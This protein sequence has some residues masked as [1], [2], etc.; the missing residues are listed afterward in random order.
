[1]KFFGNCIKEGKGYKLKLFV[2]ILFLV[3]LKK[4]SI[5]IIE[6]KKGRE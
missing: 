5:M 2:T 4:S 3:F 1:M 6:I